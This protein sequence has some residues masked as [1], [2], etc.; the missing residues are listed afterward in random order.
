MVCKLLQLILSELVLYF[1]LYWTV[2][3]PN[4]ES[5]T[6]INAGSQEKSAEPEAKVELLIAIES[7]VS[8]FK[9]YT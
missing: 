5:L 4:I 2:K 7:W 9:L 1:K 6:L 3:F 8:I